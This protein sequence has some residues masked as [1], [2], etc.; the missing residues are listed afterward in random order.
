M[1]TNTN[2]PT[3]PS[4]AVTIT[5]SNTTEYD[6]PIAVWAL[7]AGTI[8]FDA[9][10]GATNVTVAVEANTLIPVLVR[11]VRTGTSATVLGLR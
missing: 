1:S 11:R 4:S 9:A 6:P 2:I 8:V 7:T 10:I 5:P 3:W